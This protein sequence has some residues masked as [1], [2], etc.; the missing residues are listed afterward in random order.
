[1]GDGVRV[2]VPRAAESSP[3]SA[4][5]HAIIDIRCI[6]GINGNREDFLRESVVETA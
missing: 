3:A 4:T 2:N 1:M 5:T 6:P